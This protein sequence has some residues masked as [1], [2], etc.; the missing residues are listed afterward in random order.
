MTSRA[1]KLSRRVFTKL[2]VSFPIGAVI[3]N[4]LSVVSSQPQVPQKGASG[5]KPNDLGSD[6]WKLTYQA[7]YAGNSWAAPVAITYGTGDTG[8]GSWRRTIGLRNVSTRSVRS[9][10]LGAHIFNQ[11]NPSVILATTAL[12][13]TQFKERL[14]HGAA[15]TLE[16][17]DDLENIFRP[18][19]KNGVLEGQYRIELFVREVVDNVAVWHYDSKKK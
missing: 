8:R 11:D 17:K 12:P 2:L 15:V 7:H 14:A 10:G 16:G 3:F 19:M 13:A 5:D 9:I 4:G 6:S 1:S 18:F